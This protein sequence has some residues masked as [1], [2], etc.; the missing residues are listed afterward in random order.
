MN[1]SI[2]ALGVFGVLAC[3]FLMADLKEV[4][5]D[6]DGEQQNG[7]DRNGKDRE[8]KR[9]LSVDDHEALHRNLQN[10]SQ[11]NLKEISRLMKLA[12]DNLAKS[13]TGE[14]TQISQREVVKKLQELIEKVEKG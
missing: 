1:R 11:E 7:K 2:S 5:H 14:A 6:A 4:P 10:E 8:G 12:R 9:E 13:R 3:G